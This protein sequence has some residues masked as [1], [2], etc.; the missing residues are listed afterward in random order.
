MGA[1]TGT[2]TKLRAWDVGDRFGKR[3]AVAKDLTITLDTQGGGT[4]TI[5]KAALGFSTIYTVEC[6]LFV[7]GSAVKRWIAL[8]T[9]GD[10]VYTADPVVSTDADRG[11]AADVSGDLTLR[12]T[13]LPA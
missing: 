10:Y 5:G 7:D 1:Y 8:F 6:L 9:D 11:E 4:N 3:I 13:G 12:I 2:P